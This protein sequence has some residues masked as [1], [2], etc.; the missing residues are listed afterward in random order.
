MAVT[1][2]YRYR[3]SRGVHDYLC[4]ELYHLPDVDLEGYLPQVCNLLVYHAKDSVALERFVMDKCAQSMHFALQVYW[5]LQA[6]VEDA[7]RNNDRK[8][9]GKCRL[10][11]T[12]CETAAVNGSFHRGLSSARQEARLLEAELSYAPQALATTAKRRPRYLK[13]STASASRELPPRDPRKKGDTTLNRQN[14]LSK[15]TGRED[16]ERDIVSESHSELHR[17]TMSE[18]PRFEKDVAFE[19]P[20]PEADFGQGAELEK[21]SGIEESL[22]T[23]IDRMDVSEDTV[24]VK[25]G[26]R[27]NQS[28]IENNQSHSERNNNLPEREQ[29]ERAAED[30]AKLESI[31]EEGRSSQQLEPIAEEQMY[32]DNDGGDST[33]RQELTSTARQ[34]PHNGLIFDQAVLL[35]MKQERFDY[36]NDALAIMRLFVGLS[37]ALRDVPQEKRREQATKGLERINDRLLRRMI[38]EPFDDSPKKAKPMSLSPEEIAEIGEEAALRSIHLTLSRATSPALRILRISSEDTVLLTSRTRAPYMLYIE[39]LPTSMLCSDPLIFCHNVL[40]TMEQNG[41]SVKRSNAREKTPPPTV[42]LSSFRNSTDI[43]DAVPTPALTGKEKTPLERL[44]DTVHGAIY[45]DRN[46]S[47][48]SE[49]RL[50]SDEATDENVLKARQAALLAVYGELWSWKE[51]RILAKSPFHKLPGRKL[52]SFIVK[53]GDDLRQEQLAVQLIAQF[54]WIFEQEDVDVYLRPFTVVCVSSDSGLIEV[55]P[56]AVSIHSLKKRTPNFTSLLDYFIRAYG[57][58]DSKSFKVAQRKFIRSMAGYSLVTYFLQIKDR[59]NGNIMLDAE[60]HI[61]HIDF[62]FM[63]ANSPGSI[64][65]ENV[66]FKLTEEYMQVICGMHNVA[67]NYI[68]ANKSEGWLYYRELIVLGFLA[69]RKHSEKLTTLVEIVV[70]GTM[71]PCMTGGG[72]VVVDSLRQRFNLGIPERLCITNVL[73]LIEESRNSWRSV[74]YDKFQF[75]TNGYL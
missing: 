14:G 36:F 57:P 28:R 51:E 29:R 71:M 5:F 37:L 45:G 70:D 38:G 13:S 73:G 66:P 42:G 52:I 10:L 23:A 55:I 30:G 1:Y 60:G 32:G 72:H 74:S 34:D 50:G 27:R 56:D 21:G 17:R 40:H 9:E 62:G 64:K 61:I 65:F 31:S 68:G 24:D 2:L 15:G 26:R 47:A 11:R 22:S 54:K 49:N 3:E 25:E 58:V 7:G 4:N 33:Q 75:Y 63:L 8:A 41:T 20:H 35:S 53:A 12:R 18:P 16:K 39:V 43:A 46:P 19:H 59:H 44:R 48:F 67:V 6:A 69:A